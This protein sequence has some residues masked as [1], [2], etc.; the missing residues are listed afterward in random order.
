MTTKVYELY[1]RWGS[2]SV[3]TVDY[4][5]TAYLVAATSVRQAYAVA[6]KDIWIDPNDDHPV[7]IVA[8]Y[9]RD[10]GPTLWC[11]CSGHRVEGGQPAHGA[12]VRALRAA[13]ES[14]NGHCPHRQPSL[15]ERLRRHVEQ[16]RQQA[17]G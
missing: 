17:Q 15:I 13:I 16:T 10:T 5:G 8:I 7:G 2:F 3:Q 11:G 4:H 14:H 9:R 12:G 1:P 6:H